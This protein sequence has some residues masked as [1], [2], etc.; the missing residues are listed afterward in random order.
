MEQFSRVC[1]TK[2]MKLKIYKEDLFNILTCTLRSYLEAW[3]LG[4]VACIMI[5]YIDATDCYNINGHSWLT[6]LFMKLGQKIV[7]S[8][9]LP[10]SY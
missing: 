4:D 7:S 9:Y 6:C 1:I 5:V 3:S 2:S 8:P 10:A